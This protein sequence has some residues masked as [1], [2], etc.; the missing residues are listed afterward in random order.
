MMANKHLAKKHRS[1]KAMGRRGLSLFLAMVM[2]VS[3]IQI[4]VSAVSDAD[5]QASKQ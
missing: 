1:L 5:T 3:L 4:G 2:T